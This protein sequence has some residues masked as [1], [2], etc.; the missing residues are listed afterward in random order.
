MLD[1][2]FDYEIC[3]AHSERVAWRV[4]DVM[5]P[6]TRLD[7]GRRFLPEALVGSARIGCLSPDERLKLNQITGNAYLNV[8]HLVEEYIIAMA[9]DHASSEK[10]G[11]HQAMRALARFA[12]DEVKHQKLFERYRLAFDRDVGHRCEVVESQREMARM[13]LGKNPISVLLVTCHLELT[14]LHHYTAC[15]RDD[16][17]VDPFFATLLKCHWLEEAQHAKIDAL[18]LDRRASVAAPATNS[19]AGSQ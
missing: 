10:F 17:G 4:D 5:P 18:E 14:T 2:G 6:G 7:F 12:D 16:L 13:I 9:V 11:D 1:L 3:I 15:V 8:F 19:Q